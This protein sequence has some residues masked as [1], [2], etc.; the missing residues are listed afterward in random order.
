MPFLRVPHH[1][2]PLQLPRAPNPRPIN[3]PPPPPISRMQI[4]QPPTFQPTMASFY[5]EFNE[6]ERATQ[7][8]D[9]YYPITQYD[10]R[11][12]MNKP[13]APSSASPVRRERW[14]ICTWFSN[15]S[16][17]SFDRFYSFSWEHGAARRQLDLSSFE[18]YCTRWEIQSN[19]FRLI[20]LI[21]WENASPSALFT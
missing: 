4:L 5:P 1:R 6:Y 11:R 7:S 12:K 18:S 20:W 13:V 21:W 3:R 10:E 9:D 15:K 17:F 2:A 16:S 19:L 8:F 14:S